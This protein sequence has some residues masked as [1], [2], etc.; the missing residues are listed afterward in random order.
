M[1]RRRLPFTQLAL[2]AV[3]GVC[4]GIYIYRPYFEPVPKTSEEHGQDVPKKERE[5]D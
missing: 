5:T 4:G 1:F 3:L 2:A